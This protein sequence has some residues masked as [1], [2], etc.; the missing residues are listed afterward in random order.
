MHTGGEY[1]GGAET[2]ERESSRDGGLRDVHTYA[3]CTAPH[4]PHYWSHG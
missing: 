4:V 2:G 1:L 3:H